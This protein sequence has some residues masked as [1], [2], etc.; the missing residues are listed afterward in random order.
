MAS[1]AAWMPEAGMGTHMSRS[2]RANSSG[3]IVP[4]AS[5]SYMLNLFSSLNLLTFCFL[6]GVLGM[7]LICLFRAFLSFFCCLASALSCAWA[8]L[9]A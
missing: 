8:P 2:M 5:M 9:V 1:K 6:R 3:S 7:A 4:E